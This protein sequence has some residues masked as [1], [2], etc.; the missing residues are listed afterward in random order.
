MLF[1]TAKYLYTQTIQTHRISLRQ[2]L[3]NMGRKNRFA[4][5]SQ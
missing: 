1:K 2:L 4:L 5:K 3:A